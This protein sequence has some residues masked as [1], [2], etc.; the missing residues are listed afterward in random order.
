MKTNTIV[1]LLLTLNT[2]FV[3][4]LAV[5]FSNGNENSFPCTAIKQLK[6]RSRVYVKAH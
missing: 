2:R 5:S 1:R 4:K 6:F 3:E